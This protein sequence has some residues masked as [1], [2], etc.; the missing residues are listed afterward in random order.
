MYG[1]VCLCMC[2]KRGMKRG[3]TRNERRIGSSLKMNVYFWWLIL[4]GYNVPAGLL[5]IQKYTLFNCGKKCPISYFFLS[6]LFFDIIWVYVCLCTLHLNIHIISY[7]YEYL[8]IHTSISIYIIHTVYE[9][10]IN[11]HSIYVCYIRIKYSNTF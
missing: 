2:A 6:L 1:V 7:K 3:S 10:F 9:R 11:L 8:F 5:H 4:F